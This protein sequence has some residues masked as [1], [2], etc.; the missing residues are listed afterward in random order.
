MQ[1]LNVD[2]QRETARGPLPLSPGKHLRWLALSDTGAPCTM[3]SA[4]VLR[5]WSVTFGGAWT[6]LL[7]TESADEGEALWP[8]GVS[9]GDL[10]CIAVAAGSHPQVCN[11]AALTG[12][13][14]L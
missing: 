14:V 5:V 13:S 2:E 12:A 4:G 8:L 3:D 6:P 9:S 7:D 11:L 1:V 10:H